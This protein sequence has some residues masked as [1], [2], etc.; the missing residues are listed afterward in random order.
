L[1]ATF[2]DAQ[3]FRDSAVCKSA[4]AQDDDL[5]VLFGS[6][7]QWESTGFGEFAA[8]ST[9][10][11]IACLTASMARLGSPDSTAGTSE[12]LGLAGLFGGK[13]ITTLLSS[14]LVVASISP[15][16]GDVQRFVVFQ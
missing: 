11:Q 3:P 15:I 10:R 8:L 7:A 9:L 5:A 1:H 2:R 4:L 12:S 13:V 14:T 16:S 6:R